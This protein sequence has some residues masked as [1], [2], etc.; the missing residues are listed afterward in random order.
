MYATCL[1]NCYHMVP[2]VCRWILSSIVMEEVNLDGNLI[3]DGG[4]RE[5][6]QAMRERKE[7]THHMKINHYTAI[8]ISWFLVASLKATTNLVHKDFNEF[9]HAYYRHVSYYNY[10]INNCFGDII[11]LACMWV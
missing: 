6:L 2:L 7:G 4:G 1:Y 11:L 3:G 10:C 8:I 5:I 9:N